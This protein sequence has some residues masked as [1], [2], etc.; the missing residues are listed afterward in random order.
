MKSYWENHGKCIKNGSVYKK[1]LAYRIEGIAK[2][3]V[4]GVRKEPKMIPKV[5]KNVSTEVKRES[6]N[7]RFAWSVLRKRRF[8]VEKKLQVCRNLI[9]IP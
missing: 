1:R 9:G 4:P 6:E 5:L 2:T 3:P 7:K 8:R